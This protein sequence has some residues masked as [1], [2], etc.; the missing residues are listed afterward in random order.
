MKNEHHRRVI[1]LENMAF[2]PGQIAR[3]TGWSVLYVRNVLRMYEGRCFYY[4]VGS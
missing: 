3:L 1:S 4:G 2:T